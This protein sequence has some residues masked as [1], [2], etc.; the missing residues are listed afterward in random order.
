MTDNR[1]L[2]DVFDELN[3]TPEQR[4]EVTEG[5]VKAMPELLA[6]AAGVAADFNEMFDTF[7]NQHQPRGNSNA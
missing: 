4:A 2:E 7:T 3:L 1:S 6:F 5:L